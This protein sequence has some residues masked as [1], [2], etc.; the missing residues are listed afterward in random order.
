VTDF[1]GI[2]FTKDVD[3]K[4]Y[5]TVFVDAYGEKLYETKKVEV[6]TGETKDSFFGGPKEVYKKEEQRVPTGKV[7]DRIIDGH[8]LAEDINAACEHA[9]KDGYTVESVQMVTSGHYNHGWSSPSGYQNA[10]GYG[11]GYSYTEGAILL[12]KKQG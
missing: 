1:A 6:A 5:K 10:A 7:S 8:R 4:M 2:I 3:L 9:V 11:Y 12:L